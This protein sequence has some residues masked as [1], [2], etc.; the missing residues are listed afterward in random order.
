MFII[1]SLHPAPPPGLLRLQILS[2]PLLL[3]LSFIF[4]PL[5]CSLAPRPLRFSLSLS[6]F[7]SVRRRGAVRFRGTLPAELSPSRS[8]DRTVCQSLGVS[9][10]GLWAAA[11]RRS[12]LPLTK[13][14]KNTVC[15]PH[16]PRSRKTFLPRP[17][18]EFFFFNWSA[19]R[20]SDIQLAGRCELKLTRS[21]PIRF[22][23]SADRV[24]E[25]AAYLEAEGLGGCRRTFSVFTAAAL[26]PYTPRP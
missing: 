11:K 3:L 12:A 21:L 7:V 20:K 1:N 6:P 8:R 26:L 15:C 22:N 13:K 24:N 25:T 9:A 2:P 16:L 4:S 17:S 19:L 18:G 23:R 14:K 5:W 10:P